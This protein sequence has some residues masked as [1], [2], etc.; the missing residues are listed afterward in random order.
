MA[1]KV[2]AATYVSLTKMWLPFSYKFTR[3]RW[4]ATTLVPSLSLNCALVKDYRTTAMYTAE[5]H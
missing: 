1:V 3:F 4:L 5:H 2:K